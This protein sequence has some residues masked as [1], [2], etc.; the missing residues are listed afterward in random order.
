MR[1]EKARNAR[2]E[3]MGM[4]PREQT[5]GTGK[6]QVPGSTLVLR[7]KGVW[8]C[9]RNEILQSGQQMNEPQL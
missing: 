7:S 3:I 2:R 8:M 6:P 9:V 5:T 4:K 1:T